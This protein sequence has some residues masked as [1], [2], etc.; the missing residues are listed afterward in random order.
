MICCNLALEK[1][2][3]NVPSSSRLKNIF[4]KLFLFREIKKNTA[5]NMHAVKENSKNI[6]GGIKNTV[7]L[8]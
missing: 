6:I 5:V 2:G 7:M 8:M 1:R 4:P 3:D